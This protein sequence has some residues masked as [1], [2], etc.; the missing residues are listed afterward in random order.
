MAS[1]LVIDDDKSIQKSFLQ[2]FSH[3]HEVLSGYNGKEGLDIL[4]GSEVDLIFL[5]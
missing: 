5:D 3:E 1:I 4:A 2:L